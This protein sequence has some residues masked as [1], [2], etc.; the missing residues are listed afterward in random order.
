MNR[1]KKSPST[2]KSKHSNRGPDRS[3]DGR[4]GPE[5]D[6]VDPALRRDRAAAA[7]VRALVEPICVAEGLELVHVEYQR[8]ARGRTL[9]LYIDRPGGVTLDDCAHLSR[10]LGDILDVHLETEGPYRLEVSSPGLERPL[11]LPADFERFEGHEATIRT[12]RPRDGRRRFTGVLAGV[13]DEAVALRVGEETVRI[14]IDEI[15]RARLV[16][17]I[18]ENG[19]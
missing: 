17:Y 3:A 19:C 14:P 15:L 16:H 2:R 12:V 10:G 9:R 4:T 1:T 18:G 7:S 6:I 11:G 5:A 8:E 13:T